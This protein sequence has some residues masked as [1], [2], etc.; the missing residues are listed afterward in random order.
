MDRSTAGKGEAM[1]E[2]APPGMRKGKG[3]GR[4]KEKG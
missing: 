3:R 2:A 4:R 1:G